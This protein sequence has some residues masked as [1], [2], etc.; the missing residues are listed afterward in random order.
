MLTKNRSEALQRT[1]DKAL[2]RADGLLEFLEFNYSVELTC[3]VLREA[4]EKQYHGLEWT[5]IEGKKIP[6]YQLETDHL[7]NIIIAQIMGRLNIPKGKFNLLLF[8]KRA[9]ELS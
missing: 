7:E 6:V 9:R 5:T 3:A 8:E 2:S 4:R 1:I